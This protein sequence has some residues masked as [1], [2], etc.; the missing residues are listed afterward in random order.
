VRQF[1]SVVSE[2]YAPPELKAE[3]PRFNLDFV[4]RFV[5]EATM[6]EHRSFCAPVLPNTMG[7]E[8][9]VTVD[10]VTGTPLMTELLSGEAFPL[11]YFESHVATVEAE[12]AKQNMK[13][14]IAECAY[15]R[16]FVV[17]RDICFLFFPKELSPVLS[18]G[19]VNLRMDDEGVIDTYVLGNDLVCV[20]GWITTD[21]P[22]SEWQLVAEPTDDG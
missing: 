14:S 15:L 18:G 3:G 12:L 17:S 9:F 16:I 6:P 8:V 4:L 7:A 11:S 10:A 21:V 22:N 2:Y 20:D 13:I 5:D 19:R 1:G